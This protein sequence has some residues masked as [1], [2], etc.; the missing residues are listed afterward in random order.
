[1]QRLA[2]VQVHRV[3]KLNEF[4]EARQGPSYENFIRA[5]FKCL[6]ALNIKAFSWMDKKCTL[7][8]ES[9]KQL[10]KPSETVI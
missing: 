10:W 1:M 5:S 8:S 7:I 3:V 9:R 2:L 6:P 4:Y